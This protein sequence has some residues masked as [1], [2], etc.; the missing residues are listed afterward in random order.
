MKKTA[1]L[2]A[3][4]QMLSLTSLANKPAAG[5]NDSP[6]LLNFEMPFENDQYYQSLLKEIKQSPRQMA[7]ASTDVPAIENKFDA[8]FKILREE[9]IG[10]GKDKKG[11]TTIAG[12]DA[13]IN[14]YSDAKTYQG[15]SAQAQMVAL[16]LRSLKPFKSFIFRA[17]QYIGRNSATRAVI[18]S[19]L[20]AQITGIQTFFP[21]G[22]A[23]VNQWE[24]VFK[25]ITE[26]VNGMG[27]EISTDEAFHRFL[28]NV[29]SEMT[30]VF[31]DF[32]NLVKQKKTIWWDNKLYFSFANFTSEKDRYVA[33]GSPEQ[34]ALLAAMALNMSALY[35]T[36]AY[37]L[38]G[39]QSALQSVGQLF[40]IDSLTST[41]TAATSGMGADGVSS[42]TR[43]A[44][45]NKHP[46]LFTLMPDG[47]QR[48]SVAF[49]FLAASSRASRISFEETKRLPEG[50]ENLFDPRVANAF[51]RL[52]GLSLSNMEQVISDQ[53]AVTSA[54]VNG[55]R[56]KISL[57]SFYENPP[58]HL[59]ELYP[60]RWDQTPD[61]IPV[62]AWGKADKLRNY[63][64]GMA[65]AWNYQ[66]YKKIFPDIKSKDGKTTTEVPRYARVL[67][68][69]WGASAFALPLSAVIF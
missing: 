44:I 34:H 21:T 62:T 28:V 38:T 60:V 43:I 20:R 52:G 19:M 5:A 50:Q 58:E 46:K 39:L 29:T 63:K 56:I 17:R 10:N 25:Y 64:R 69:T 49:K 33:L 16:Q 24:V 45:L 22:G 9:L 42:Q 53:E 54:V 4:V 12:L 66:A 48:M 65:V 14:K 6:P 27:A 23:S 51:A 37:S 35:S 41:V 55:E 2:I 61:L 3:I 11:V 68:Q 7:A 18:V 36:T 40:G 57:K 13:L 1:I 15:L 59:N 26:P 47:R 8:D 31:A 30:L 32:S 67:A